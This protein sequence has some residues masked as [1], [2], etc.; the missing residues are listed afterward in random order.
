MAKVTESKKIDLPSNV[1][2]MDLVNQSIKT[3][4]ANTKGNGL[5]Q[6]EESAL[7]KLESQP[8]IKQLLAFALEEAAKDGLT[9]EEVTETFRDVSDLIYRV[10]NEAKFKTLLDVPASAQFK[11]TPAMVLAIESLSPEKKSGL[12]QELRQMEP[13]TGDKILY[14]FKDLGKP[15]LP[16]FKVLGNMIL[17]IG[18]K[19]LVATVKEKVPGAG[20]DILAT[21]VNEVTKALGET[22]LG[23]LHTAEKPSSVVAN[24]ADVAA[25]HAPAH[26]DE[27]PLAGADAGHTDAT[28]HV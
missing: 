13:T 21:G 7:R 15:F 16:T 25:H 17:N 20:G 12:W 27:K 8:I 10:T 9:S 1:N 28:H 24:L 23:D 6:T 22:V 4:L 18:T 14:T 26:V 3:I 11:L 19:T 2:Y 5:G